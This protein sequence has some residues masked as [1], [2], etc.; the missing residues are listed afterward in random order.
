LRQ[1][2]RVCLGLIADI[3]Q[4]GWSQQR[5]QTPSRVTRERRREKE[6]LIS[7]YGI[8]YHLFNFINELI[9]SETVVPCHR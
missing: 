1:L 2:K 8:N 7:T 3:T 6:K 4:T 5:G 9:N